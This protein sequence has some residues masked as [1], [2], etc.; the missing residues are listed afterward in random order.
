VRFTAQGYKNDKSWRVVFTFIKDGFAKMG[1][2]RLLGSLMKKFSR[3]PM[4]AGKQNSLIERHRLGRGR[5]HRGISGLK[6]FS[7]IFLRVFKSAKICEKCI[8]IE[9]H[10]AVPEKQFRAK[11]RFF[12]CTLTHALK[13]VAIDRSGKSRMWQFMY[14]TT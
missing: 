3:L 7:A 13:G 8:S 14:L 12:G 9:N 11:A 10:A 1:D 6:T 2:Q 4:P 5:H